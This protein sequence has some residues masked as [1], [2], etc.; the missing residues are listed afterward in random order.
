MHAEVLLPDLIRLDSVQ[1]ALADV[2]A[3]KPVVVVH[4]ESPDNEGELIFAADCATPEL[5]AFMVRYTSGYVCVA[6]TEGEANRLG[7]PPVCHTY[8]GQLGPAYAVAVDAREGVTTGIS[9]RDRARTIRL[10]SDPEAGIDDLTRPGHVVPIRVKPGG[11][12]RWPEHP[13]AAVDIAVLAGRRP[14]AAMSAIVSE[15]SPKTMA[16]SEELRDFADRHDLAM[17]SIADLVA[18]R[19]LG[20]RLVWRAGHARG[21]VREGR[22]SN[23]NEATQ[24]TWRRGTAGVQGGSCP[25]RG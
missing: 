11:A 24:M 19:R 8:Q 22:V 7:L 21:S 25:C 10:L 5:V 18:Y 4:D 2:A 9:A 23:S 15:R 6:V 3:G 17:M 16:R 1:R 14:A 12:V 20:D 13:E